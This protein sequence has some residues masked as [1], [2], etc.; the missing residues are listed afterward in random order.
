MIRCDF[1]NINKSRTLDI[2]G[3]LLKTLMQVQVHFTN[4]GANT[5][6][7]TQFAHQHAICLIRKYS[8]AY[9]VNKISH[10]QIPADVVDAPDVW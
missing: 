6:T 9:F 3:L 5:C 7:R 2:I 10:F 8:T 1:N 4:R